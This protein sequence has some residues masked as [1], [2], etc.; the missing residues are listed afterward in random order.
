[1]NWTT[2]KILMMLMV[3]CMIVI[4]LPDTIEVILLEPAEIQQ[5]CCDNG[6]TVEVDGIYGKDTLKAVRALKAERGL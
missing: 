4:C 3:I 6:Q 1:M 5:Y 2:T